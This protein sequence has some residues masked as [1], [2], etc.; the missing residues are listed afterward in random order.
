MSDFVHKLKN[1]HRVIQQVVAGMS[2]VR[3]TTRF[4]QAS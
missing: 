2:A 1:D 3:K 4:R